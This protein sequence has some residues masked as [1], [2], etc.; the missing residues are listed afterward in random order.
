MSTIEKVL[1]FTNR[2]FNRRKFLGG[3]GAAGLGAAAATLMGGSLSSLHASGPSSFQPDGITDED[4]LN[5]A[6]N[7]EYLEAEFYTVAITGKYIE[8]IGIGVNG[9]GTY[10]ATTGGKLVQ[11]PASSQLARIAAEIAYDEQQ[12]VLFLRSALN[13]MQIAK[14]AINLDALGIG[15]QS[16][17]QFLTL[18]RAFEDVGVSA[19]GGAAPLIANKT[20]LG[21]AAR[22]AET[23][24]LHSGNIRLNV[25]QFK[26][27]VQPVDGLDVLPPPAGQN[28]FTV[29]SQALAVI[30]TPSQVLAIVYG[31]S[32]PGTD[33]G[34]F[35]PDGVNGNINTV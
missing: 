4:I 8:Q 32:A 20:T 18:A 30:R 26:I 5:F 11:F 19:Y 7:L 2:G 1:H 24:A 21:Y 34:G 6:L 23:E 27:Y 29:N 28:F 22:I 3:V 12:H 25:A 16:W 9:S 33:S 10:G 17:K 31:N 14:P 15:F 35:F 13:G